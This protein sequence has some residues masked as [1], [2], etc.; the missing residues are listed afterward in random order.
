MKKWVFFWICFI[1]SQAFTANANE[2]RVTLGG[3]FFGGLYLEQH[4]SGSTGNTGKRK[5]FNVDRFRLNLKAILNENW[6]FVTRIQMKNGQDAFLRSAYIEGENVFFTKDRVRFGTFSNFYKTFI[7]QHITTRWLNKLGLH[8]I[9][10]TYN[11]TG[12][13][14]S[15]RY[16]YKPGNFTF[17]VDLI[18]GEEDAK[19]DTSNTVNNSNDRLG[20]AAYIAYKMGVQEFHFFYSAT[21]KSSYQNGSSF[22]SEIPARNT[23][24]FDYTLNMGILDLVAEYDIHDNGAGQKPTRIHLT[25]DYNYM[26]Q[27]SFFLSIN[28]D[29]DDQSGDQSESKKLGYILGP[30]FKLDNGLKTAVTYRFQS[31]ELS[32]EVDEKTLAW[33]FEAKF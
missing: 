7:Y 5:A 2:M 4:E 10:T 11:L 30:V 14:A 13:S 12:E 28:S 27:K 9:D 8:D 22:N 19:T 6:H 26:D 24:A 33:N 16:I 3:H 17:G 15:I 1:C 23:M 29:N 21:P 20:Y 18:N 32:T 31:Y 25:A